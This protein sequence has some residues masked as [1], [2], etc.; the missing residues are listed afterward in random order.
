MKGFA[1]MIADK[2][3]MPKEEAEDYLRRYIK[4]AE[5]DE[6]LILGGCGQII[7]KKV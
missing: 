5:N 3:V 7:A 1:A 4:A 2:G 6:I